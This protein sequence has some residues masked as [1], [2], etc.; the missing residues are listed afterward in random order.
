MPEGPPVSN[1]RRF[2]SDLCALREQSGVSLEEMHEA[3]KIP[4]NLLASFED[5]GLFDNPMFN[6]VYLR[7]F[8]RMY[9][10]IVGLPA[11][12]A[13]QALERAL[14][15]RYEGDLTRPADATGDAPDAEAPADPPARGDEAAEAAAEVPAHTSAT[16]PVE[17]AP[18]RTHQGPPASQPVATPPPTDPGGWMS[19][20]PPP[21]APRV[22]STFRTGPDLFPWLLGAGALLVLILVVWF[23]FLRGGGEPD[24]APEPVA[25]TEDTTQVAA[26]PPPPPVVLGDTIAVR[27]FPEG[28]TIQ[29]L[30]TTLDED[31]RRPYWSE[32]DSSL[33]FPVRNRIIIEDAGPG[34][35]PRG[36]LEHIRIEIE[37]E[38][39]P[40]TFRD[41]DGRV[42]ITR[43]T[44]QVHLERVRGR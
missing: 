9:A 23:F 6:R 39:Y 3:T 27:I 38:P 18:R 31:V 19:A 33:F 28:E 12:R 11:D 22:T 36:Q 37:G 21:G 42:V 43:D 35:G 10:D 34:L 14:E 41:A 25:A 32:L 8:V 15:G 4:R 30:R 2:A 1:G 7:S 16:R 24:V 13:L 26:P 29:G 5:S 17:A 20:S 40:A 44:A